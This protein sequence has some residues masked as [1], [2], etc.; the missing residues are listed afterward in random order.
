MRS[1][2]TLIMLFFVVLLSERISQVLGIQRSATLAGKKLELYAAFES[3]LGIN[4]ISYMV[5]VKREIGY[6]LSTES[7]DCD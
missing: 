3:L 5:S 1:Y 2:N 7:G 6:C 4:V